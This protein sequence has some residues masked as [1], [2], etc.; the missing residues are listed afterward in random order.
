M[1]KIQSGCIQTLLDSNGRL[2]T[3]KC[4]LP[5]PKAAVKLLQHTDLQYIK[6]KWYYIVESL[7][8]DYLWYQ[9]NLM[10][11][12]I[13]DWKVCVFEEKK[14]RALENCTNYVINSIK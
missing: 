1:K 3:Y 2:S 8:Y 12:T 5:I 10:Q 6:G 4:T 11:V 7:D 9:V 14:M 13:N